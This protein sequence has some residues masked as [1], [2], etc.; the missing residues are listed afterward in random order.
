MCHPE[1]NLSERL[2][3]QIRFSYPLIPLPRFFSGEGSGVGVQAVRIVPEN[4]IRGVSYFL[5]I[6]LSYFT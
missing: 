5:Y 2:S 4:E 6:A 1:F 3:F